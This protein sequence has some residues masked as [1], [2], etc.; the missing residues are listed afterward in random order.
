[1][2]ISTLNDCKNSVQSSRI[3]I[4]YASD[5]KLSKKLSNEKNTKPE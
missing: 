3:K 5:G 1:M 2:K 4:K